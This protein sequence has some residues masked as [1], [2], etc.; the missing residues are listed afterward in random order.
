V[1]STI[2]MFILS[3]QL[4]EYYIMNCIG[5]VTMNILFLLYIQGD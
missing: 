1:D 2:T 5:S 3:I 4:I